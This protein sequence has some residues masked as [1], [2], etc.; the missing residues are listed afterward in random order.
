M[1]PVYLAN[2][3]T[4]TNNVA[5][6]GGTD[7]HYKGRVNFDQSGAWRVNLKVMKNGHEYDTYFDVTY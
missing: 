1:N 2:G 3:H 6:T 4:T 7:G 5:P